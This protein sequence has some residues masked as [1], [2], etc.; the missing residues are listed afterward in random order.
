[1]NQSEKWIYE[2]EARKAKERDKLN[3]E[4]K[5]TAYGKSY[6]QVEREKY[7]AIDQQMKMTQEIESTVRSLDCCTCELNL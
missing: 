7:E 4:K 5:Y 6:A 3:L 2:E 1:M